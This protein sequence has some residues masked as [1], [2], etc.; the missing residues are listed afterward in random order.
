[1][2]KA[3]AKKEIQKLTS[4]IDYYNDQYYQHQ[5]S[6]ITDYAFDQL[7]TEL[8]QLEAKFPTLQQKSS[9]T[10]NVGGVPTNILNTVIHETP[11]LSL[12]NSY[13][14]TAVQAFVNRVQKKYP[15]TPI[16][17]FCELKFDGIAMSIVYKKGILDQVITRGD[18]YKGDI[19]TA[20]AKTISTLPQTIHAPNCPAYM[21]VRGEIFM[22][23]AVFTASNQQRVKAGLSPLANPRNAAAGTLKMLDSK[24][25]AQR[26]LAC[27]VYALLTD[28]LPLSTQADRMQQLQKWRFP[29]SNT[30]KTCT[31]V[32]EIMAYIHY[33][34]V[35]KKNL[36]MAVDGIVIKVNN[37]V[38][39]EQLGATAKSPRWA[40][41]YKYT[42]AHTTT[43][44]LGVKFQV[45]RTGAITPV[46]ELA[47]VQLAGSTIKRASLHNAQ[48]IQRL[49]LRIGDDVYIEKG[50]EI[51]PKIIGIDLTKRKADSLPIHFITHCPACH[52]ALVQAPGEAA[53]YC[54]NH[55][56]CAPQIQGSIAHFVHRKAMNVASIGPETIALLYDHGLVHTPADL[57]TLDYTTIAGLERFQALSTKNLLQGIQNTKQI[58]FE[59]V[60]FALGIRHVGATAAVTLAQHFQTLTALLAATVDQL[61]AVP[62]IGERIANSVVAYFQTPHHRAMVDR[63]QQAGLQFAIRSTDTVKTPLLAG[64]KFIISG[65]FK[66]GERTRV[67]LLITQQGGKVV[68]TI[69]P[70][71]D[72]LVIGEKPGPAKLAKAKKFNIPLLTEAAW[73]KMMHL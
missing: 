57:Y 32:A 58:P 30:S 52:T 51:I 41:A 39:Q 22:T 62:T 3:A 25:V 33:W 36:P 4:A 11:M 47:P 21:V 12:T 23:F 18:G 9:P 66:Y 55:D 40:I 26:H 37:I 48:E 31:T 61:L 67:A 69:G 50:G 56:H 54:H 63:L 28:A 34:E 60:L 44:L 49:Q 46:A 43:R 42:P 17:F 2:T 7:L 15:T 14:V 35:H 53:Y 45:G 1:M 29:V 6:A 68:S 70:T 38:Q 24:L 64:K 19:I 73:L 27:Y 13:A 5:R 72:Y 71:L 16:S 8:T 20:N 59:K 10:Q 65:Q